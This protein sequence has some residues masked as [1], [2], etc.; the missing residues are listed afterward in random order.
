APSAT[1]FSLGCGNGFIEGDLVG[2]DRRVRG[3]DY[4]DEAVRL[5]RQKGVDAFAGYFFDLSPADVAGT[6]VLY[7]DGFLGH[8]FDPQETVGP[9]LRKLTE[10]NP[11]PGTHVVLSNDAPHDPAA[12]FTPHER[13]AGFWFV[14]REYLQNELVT[15]GV[16]SG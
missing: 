11:V 7:A 14:S 15:F 6:D 5:A 1:V 8:V 9:A 12:D 10:L 4:N 3:I 2:L 13:V 16:V